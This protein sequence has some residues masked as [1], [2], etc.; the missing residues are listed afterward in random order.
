MDFNTALTMGEMD[1][2]INIKKH[3]VALLVNPSARYGKK[4]Q[5]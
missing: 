5:L 4:E 2:W 1:I 3:R